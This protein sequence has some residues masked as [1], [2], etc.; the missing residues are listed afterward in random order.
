MLRITAGHRM[1]LQLAEAAGEGH[2][3]GTAEVLVAQEQHLVLEQQL[4]DLGEQ[5]V[6][7]CRVAQVH[8]TDFGADGTG[9]L[10]YLHGELPR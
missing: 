4:P 9:Q 2:V 8:A 5:A 7:A 10:F 3:I 6:V 1:I